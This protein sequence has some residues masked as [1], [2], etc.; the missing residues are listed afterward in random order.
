MEIK[1]VI[2]DDEVRARV[3]LQLLLEEYC[4]TIEII[5]QCETLAEGIRA[6]NKH[7]PNLVFLDI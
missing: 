4:P 2:I 7:S 6:I 5:E 3:S 1:A